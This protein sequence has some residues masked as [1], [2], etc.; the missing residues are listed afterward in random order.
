MFTPVQIGANILKKALSHLGE[1]ET[2]LGS[3]QGVEVNKYL[4]YVGMPP[5]NQW[6]ACFASYCTGMTLLQMDCHAN[7][8]RTASSHEAVNWAIQHHTVQTSESAV[9]GDWAILRGG[10]G[11]HAADG[12]AYEHT[13]LVERIDVAAGVAHLVSGNWHDSVARS[14]EPLAGLTILR[15]YVLA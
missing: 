5:G 15:P 6:C 1:H 8:L 13:T 4:Q 2:P 12:R 11:E 7:V 3:N 9:L 10:S 14:V